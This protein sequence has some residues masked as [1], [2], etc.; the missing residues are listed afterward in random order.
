VYPAVPPVA[1]AVAV[2]LLLEQEVFVVDTPTD[3]ALAGCVT[4]PEPLAVT[5]SE[6]TVTE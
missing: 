1:F 6:V 5:P 4:V 2:P 3:T